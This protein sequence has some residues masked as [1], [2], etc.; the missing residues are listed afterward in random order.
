M[1]PEQRCGDAPVRRVDYVPDVPAAG[2]DAIQVPTIGVNSTGLF[3]LLNWNTP[4]GA[5]EGP[6]GLVMHL[7]NGAS[8]PA[9]LASISGGGSTSRQGLAVT[10]TAAIFSETREGGESQGAVLSVSPGEEPT[11]LALTAGPA[12]ALVADEQNVYFVDREGIKSV[13]LTGGPVRKLADQTQTPNTIMVA[14][15]TLYLAGLGDQGSLSSVPIHGGPVTVLAAENALQPVMCGETVCWLNG[16]ALDMRLRQLIPEGSPTTLATGL[17]EPHDLVFDGRHFFVTI[18]I[19][20]GLYRIPAA[21]GQAVPIQA[22]G[23]MT[24]LALDDECLYWSEAN[25][26]YTWGLSAASQAP[27][28]ANS[29]PQ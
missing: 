19:V 15:S 26:I 28:I 16:P 25:G 20:L 23:L 29:G 1:A 4:L 10:Q 11:T 24:S 14:G 12:H 22:G 9:R 3:Y 17:R 2:R 21:G 13:P 8:E 7:P 6:G 5:A 27:E 18:S